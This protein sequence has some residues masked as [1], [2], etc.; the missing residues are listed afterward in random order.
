MADT[1]P[2]DSVEPHLNGDDYFMPLL[3]WQQTLWSQLTAKANQ[4]GAPLPHA[5][6]AAGIKGIGKRQFIWHLVA[7]LLCH[8]REA[9]AAGACGHCE[10]CDWLRSG[11]HP[12]LQVLPLSS[13]L[14][15]PSDSVTDQSSKAKKAAKST[16][17]SQSS[18]PK[19][20]D[21]V[22]HTIKID[23][24]RKLIN[25][26]HQGSQGVRVCVFDYAEQM[27]IGAANALLKTLE[28]PQ[29]QV[30]LLLISDSP[31]QLLPTIKS[32]VQQLP[33]SPIPPEMAKSYLKT[34]LLSLDNDHQKVFKNNHELDGVN[35]QLSS[36]LDQTVDQLLSLANGA[37][38]AALAMASAPWY[39]KRPLWLTTWLAVRA[40][41]RSALAAS[42]YWQQQLDLNEFTQLT[43][44]M[45]TD[46]SRISLGLPSLQHD[47]QIDQSISHDY[48][49]TATALAT[50]A[51][52]INESKR[53][54]QQNVQEKL[55]YD[56]L[57][58]AI[59]ET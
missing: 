25:F 48:L 49:P 30:H 22:N 31:A 59:A 13:Q 52:V 16:S 50:L 28:E 8:R 43:E 41:K 33:L 14:V 46:I 55:A 24:I 36:T 47:C 7:W 40:G 2:V 58:Q 1:A 38:L 34:A 44:L 19:S 51:A 45:L 3:P 23:D 27:T 17:S 10:S 5:M 42:D 29:P 15:S 39:D 18:N 11:T 21:S 26:V 20:T 35:N 37:P 6:L 53:A 57:M 56:K 32:R 9:H 4:S 54:I 12:N